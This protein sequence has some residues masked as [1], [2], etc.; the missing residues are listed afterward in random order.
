MNTFR[1]PVADE[2]LWRQME[3]E[4]IRREIIAGEIARRRELEEEVS[5]ELAMERTFGIPMERYLAT[6]YSFL[7]RMNPLVV[8]DINRINGE[9]IKPSSSQINK[10]RV[11]MLVSLSTL[12]NSY[13]IFLFFIFCPH[14]NFLVGRTEVKI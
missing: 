12:Y 9:E 3:K 4:K 11:I 14:T 2:A 5:R 8:D 7:E 6:P 10:D 1:V 13:S